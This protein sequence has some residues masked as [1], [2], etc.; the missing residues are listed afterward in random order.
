MDI[1][2]ANN[3]PDCRFQTRIEEHL[4]YIDYKCRDNTIILV[5]TEVPAA[6]EGKG[7]G[8]KLAKAA[9]EFARQEG[10]RV[11]AECSFI[12]SYIDRHPEYQPLLSDEASG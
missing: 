2:T 8:S 3:I 11:S 9:L 10:L 7:V 5:H 6:L 1:S 12:A 4:A